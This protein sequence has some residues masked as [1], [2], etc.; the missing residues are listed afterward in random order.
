MAP[1]P[2]TDV[3]LDQDTPDTLPFRERQRRR[4]EGIVLER[5]VVAALQALAS[6]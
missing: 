1:T 3:R 6:A 4:V 5:K 2:A